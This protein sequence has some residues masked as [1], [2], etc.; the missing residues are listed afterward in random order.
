MAIKQGSFGR[1]RIFEDFLGNYVTA[2][3]TT[4]FSSIGQLACISVD[5]A[6]GSVTSTVDEPGGVVCIN[7]HSTDDDNAA[8]FAGVFKPADGGVVMEARCKLASATTGALFIG[9]SE[10][11]AVTTPVMP[12]EFATATLAINGSGAVIGML[13]DPDATTDIWK[14]V[15]GDGGVAADNA[16]TNASTS[17][18]ADTWDVVRV[19]VGADGDGYV[20]LNGKLIRSFPNFMTTTD[21]LHAV[22]MAENRGSAAIALEMDYFYAEG[23]RDWNDD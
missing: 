19:E 22:V 3:P 11:L 13:F 12:A 15:A 9:F 10:T 16:P 23:G 4:T 7:T 18:V 2:D 21:I 20:Y 6:G 1:I 14:A 17:L 8:V 5:A